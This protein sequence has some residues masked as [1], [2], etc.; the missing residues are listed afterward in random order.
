MLLSRSIA[1]REVA[2]SAVGSLRTFAAGTAP[3]K[4]EVLYALNN[5]SD[6]DAVGVVNSYL[7]AL[8]K[9][10]KVEP[11]GN[12]EGLELTSKIEKKYAAAQV[13]ENGIQGIS[14]PL[15]HD[16]DGVAS[17]KRYVSQ[18]L[19]LGSQA[20]FE[21]PVLEVEKKLTE[22]AQTAESVKELLSRAQGL[23]S[24][25]LHAA[26]LEAVQQVEAE[27]NST[28]LL[29]GSSAGYK[30][31]AQKVQAV[32]TAHKLPWKLLLDAKKGAGDE[33]AK[34]KTAKEYAA[35]LQSARVADA[36]AELELLKAEAAS[37]LDKQLSKTAEQVRKEQAA[38]L[39]QAIKKAEAAKGAPWA[40]AFLEDVERVKWFDA[41]VAENPAVGPKVAA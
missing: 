3:S 5:K 36:V 24:A 22:H 7:T 8:Y 21:D 4:K 12:D 11:S 6:P 29:D 37:L 38:M 14:V 41:C 10:G 15:S 35:W 17:V 39:Q 33:D 26:L 34:D 27:T 32:A 16:K 9:G 19:S 2:S 30:A 13:V 25:E 20:G 18:L 28:V 23:M 1:G 31:F 40:K